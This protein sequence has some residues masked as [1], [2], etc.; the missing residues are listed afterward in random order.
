MNRRSALAAA[1]AISL[2]ITGIAAAAGATM[3]VFDAAEAS[4]NLGKVVATT[5]TGLKA[6]MPHHME[7]AMPPAGELLFLNAHHL[8]SS[9]LVDVSNP[10]APRIAKTFTPPSP[11][12]YPHD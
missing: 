4:P 8:E 2:S 1:A 5:P 10:L 6:S 12:R 7:Y 9:M 11:F 3:H